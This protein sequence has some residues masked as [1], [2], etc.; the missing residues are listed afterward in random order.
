VAHVA[1]E[2]AD[3]AEGTADDVVV[4]GAYDDVARV[5]DGIVRKETHALH[6][7]AAFRVIASVPCSKWTSR[8][9][10]SR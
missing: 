4:D 9:P 3:V 1:T 2:D 6:G 10:G 7:A 5:G 8:D